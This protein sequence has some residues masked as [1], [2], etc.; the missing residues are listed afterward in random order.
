M[1]KDQLRMSGVHTGMAGEFLSSWT[2]L[3]KNVLPAC[4]LALMLSACGGLPNPVDIIP[5]VGGDEEDENKLEGDRISVLSLDQRLEVDPALMDID[6]ALPPPYTNDSWPQAGGYA[7]HA[8]HHLQIPANID[9]VWRSDA[10]E[11]SSDE[12]RI[13]ASPV[14]ADGK[15]FV[16]DAKAGVTAFDMTTGAKIW[17]V[18]LT[19]EDEKDYMGTG[20]GVAY[21]NGRVFATTG[22]GFVVALSADNG[23]ELWRQQL[24]LAVR[25]APTVDGG[26]VFAI[27]FDNQLFALAAEDGRVLW[28]HQGIEE[29]ARL[30]VSTSPAV[31]GDVVVAPYSSGEVFAIRV[32]NGRIAWSDSLT[33]TGRLTPLSALNDIAGRPVIDRGLVYAV[34]HSGR[35]V[36]IDLR[37]GMRVWS[38]NIGGTQ[39]PWVAGDF[40]YV[41]TIDSELVC[42]SRK[43]GR[44]RW[45]TRLPQFKD[46]K[47][48]D[49]PIEWSGPV[50]AGDRLIVVSSRA[51]AYSISPYT[52]DVLGQ[53]E[54]PD[55]TFIPPIVANEMVFVLTDEAELIAMR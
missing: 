51:R 27:T 40:V 23:A 37:S 38:K 11:G 20:G 42:L 47:D 46:P 18:K 43:D 31:S 33:R 1:N 12:A 44:I 16:R 2:R 8:M 34:S 22:F 14:A 32:Q 41:L 52:G 53:I 10:G 15:V 9:E 50:L 49:D 19:P 25:A 55:G 5:F 29:N 7:S 21:A 39:T 13:T 28:N 26:R 30:F 6:V 48:R 35:M 54:M 4:G 45:I 24:G 17:Q 36:A 3:F